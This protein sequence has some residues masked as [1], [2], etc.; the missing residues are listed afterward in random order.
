MFFKKA[1]N[2]SRTQ[3]RTASGRLT[4]SCEIAMI[5]TG[6]KRKPL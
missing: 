6:D 5:H 2:R 1:E 4:E 3:V